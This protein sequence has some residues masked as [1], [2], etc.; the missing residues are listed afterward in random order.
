MSKTKGKK[1]EV[2]AKEIAE[3]AAPEEHAAEENTD[4]MEAEDQA[5]MK[6]IEV[7]TKFA[8]FFL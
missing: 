8:V 2:P 4:E 1:E 6:E 5:R 7:I 3:P